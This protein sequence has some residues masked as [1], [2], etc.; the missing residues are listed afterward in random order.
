MWHCRRRTR[1]KTQHNATP[2]HPPS[3][4]KNPRRVSHKTGQECN[5]CVDVC[6]FQSHPIFSLVSWKKKR[7]SVA[8]VP[9]GGYAITRALY[10]L[11]IVS[12]IQPRCVIP[13]IVAVA[14]R[15][16]GCV[17]VSPVCYAGHSLS[18]IRPGGCVTISPVCY[19]GYILSGIRP[20][21]VF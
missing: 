14:F 16:R 10:Q 8:F 17:T 3:R 6:S 5:P 4:Q 9:G 7:D 19:T 12:G 20:R 21:G 1:N 18:G 15:P 11:Y 2:H 13:A